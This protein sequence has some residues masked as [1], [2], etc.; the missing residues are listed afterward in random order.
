MLAAVPEDQPP[1]G[2]DREQGEAGAGV[3]SGAPE[4]VTLDP[5]PPRG[6][7]PP[8]CALGSGSLDQLDSSWV[9]PGG[10]CSQHLC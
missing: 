9:N 4:V 8:P 3:G 5:L 6:S 7:G 2:G 1:R 10:L